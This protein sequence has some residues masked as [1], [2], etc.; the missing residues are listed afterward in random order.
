MQ[1][2]MTEV[3]DSQLNPLAIAFIPTNLELPQK[4]PIQQSIESE[5]K[6][7]ATRKK[8]GKQNS[9]DKK[10]EYE[11]AEKITKKLDYQ[12]EIW[13]DVIFFTSV[14]SMLNVFLKTTFLDETDCNS[15]GGSQLPVLLESLADDDRK[16]VQKSQANIAPKKVEEEDKC[17]C[18]PMF[19]WIVPPDFIGN[20]FNFKYECSKKYPHS[21]NCRIKQESVDKPNS[22]DTKISQWT[23]DECYSEMK[24]IIADVYETISMDSDPIT[25]WDE[26]YIIKDFLEIS[27]RES[28]EEEHNESKGVVAESEA[29]V[30]TKF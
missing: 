2:N 20:P 14:T 1:S 4:G 18:P 7:K 27:D 11:M 26:K 6:A 9:N 28:D 8:K 25:K 16:L 3:V 29:R 5:N 13:K 21:P 22:L 23:L 24:E 19:G 17:N 15:I 30:S 12:N 10:S